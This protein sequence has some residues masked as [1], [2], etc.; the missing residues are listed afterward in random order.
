MALHEQSVGKSSD[1]RTPFYI[2]KALGCEFDVDV[3]SPGSGPDA[4]DTGQILHHARQ[5]E[6]T[7]AWLRMDECA[8]RRARRTGTVASEIH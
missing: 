6:R 1:W 3:A 4:V 2:F 7:L 8:V 5:L